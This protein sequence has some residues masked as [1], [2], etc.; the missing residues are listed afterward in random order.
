MCG[1]AAILPLHFHVPVVRVGD[2]LRSQARRVMAVHVLGHS[3]EHT[4]DTRT[5]RRLRLALASRGR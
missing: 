4:L 1:N 5:R 2:L 3:P